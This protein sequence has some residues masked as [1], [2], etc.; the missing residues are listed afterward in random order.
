MRIYKDCYRQGAKIRQGTPLHVDVSEQTLAEALYT[1]LARMSTRN[2]EL[3]CTVDE[4]VIVIST[5]DEIRFLYSP[6]AP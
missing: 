4:H 3:E 2:V 6:A 1:V 5:R